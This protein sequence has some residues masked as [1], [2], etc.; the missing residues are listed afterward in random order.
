M[1]GLSL[2]IRNAVAEGQFQAVHLGCDI[3]ISHSF[4]V[5]DVLI[6]GMLNR[7]AWLTHFHI[8]AKF[9]N[10]TGLYMNLQKSIVFHGICDMEVIA[11]IHILFGVASELMSGGMKYLGYHIK[12]C[13]YKVNDW[14]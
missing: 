5:D 4:F 8:F 11:Y 7:L 9:A 1:D 10:A 14:M 6:M 3:R 2:H 12:P 13:S